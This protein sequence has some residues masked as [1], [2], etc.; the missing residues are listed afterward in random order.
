MCSQVV[1]VKIFERFDD[2]G[3]VAAELT[4]N[5]ASMRYELNKLHQLDHPYVVKLIGVITNL[6]SF[7]LEWAPLVSLELQRKLYI[8]R[9]TYM[10]PTSVVLAMLCN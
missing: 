8:E 7:V 2:V 10:C 4:K 1:A 9:V 3:D 6:H 5:Y